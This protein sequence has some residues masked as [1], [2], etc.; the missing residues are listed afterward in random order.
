MMTMS[1]KDEATASKEYVFHY[2]Q[3]TR[4]IF[5]SSKKALK[6]P[7]QNIY[8]MLDLLYH[9]CNPLSTTIVEGSIF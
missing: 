2:K 8:L 7:L 3:R 9:K 5:R 1:K 4:F 6:R